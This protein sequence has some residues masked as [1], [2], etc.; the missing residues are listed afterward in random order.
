MRHLLDKV[1]TRQQVVSETAAQLGQQIA[2]L[3]EQLA[4][5][6]ATLDRLE[7]TRA[8]STKGSRCG[9]DL[10]ACQSRSREMILEG[11]C[12]SLPLQVL[13]RPGVEEVTNWPPVKDC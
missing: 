5:A 2:L 10:A 12:G 6:E 9:G 3:S 7:I 13:A 11:F 4:A 1:E 8:A